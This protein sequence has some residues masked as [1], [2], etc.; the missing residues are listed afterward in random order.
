MNDSFFFFFIIQV[1]LLI[2]C[3]SD[4]SENG[5]YRGNARLLV[6]YKTAFRANVQSESDLEFARKS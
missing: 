2:C 3:F 4:M 5:Q 6:F 1:V